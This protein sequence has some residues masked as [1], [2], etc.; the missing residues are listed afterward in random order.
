M[1]GVVSLRSDRFL[2]IAQLSHN[3]WLHWLLVNVHTPVQLPGGGPWFR[4]VHSGH[5]AALRADIAF[6]EWQESAPH[7]LPF[8]ST[9]GDPSLLCTDQLSA[10]VPRR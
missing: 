9:V 7:P 6:P 5:P 1:H 10:Q 3:L 8:V 2:N 4:P